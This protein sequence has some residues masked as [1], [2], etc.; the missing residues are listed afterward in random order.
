MFLYKRG[1]GLI[2]LRN[3]LLLTPPRKAPRPFWCS[4]FLQLQ[5][6]HPP[7][8]QHATLDSSYSDI[9]NAAETQRRSG[10]L[11]LQLIGR[12]TPTLPKATVLT[13]SYA[14]HVTPTTKGSPASTHLTRSSLGA[15]AR[16]PGLP[17]KQTGS[18]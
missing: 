16:L 4:P 17:G 1:L 2:E 15:V 9:S 8:L 3:R 18:E 12:P 6:H 11:S 13:S 5:P 7:S 14:S 10:S